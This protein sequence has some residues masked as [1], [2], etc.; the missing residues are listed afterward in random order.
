MGAIDK[1]EQH[2]M[3]HQQAEQSAQQQI[4]HLTQVTSR[5]AS[6]INQLTQL[7]SRQA[8]QI[9]AAGKTLNQV[10]DRLNKNTAAIREINKPFL[11]KIFN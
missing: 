8:A 7:T 4:E 6:Q 2:V 11:K 1:I 10:I 9:E 5:Q 3:S